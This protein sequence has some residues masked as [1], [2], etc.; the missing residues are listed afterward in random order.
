MV[1]LIVN[2][3]ADVE[4]FQIFNAFSLVVLI[5]VGAVMH[6]LS[7][8]MAHTLNELDS[9]CPRVHSLKLKVAACH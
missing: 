6:Y 9:H 1:A 2:V 4:T 5:V 7:T 8:Q 3:C